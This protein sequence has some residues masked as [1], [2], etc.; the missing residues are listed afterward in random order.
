LIPSARF[1]LPVCNVTGSIPYWLHSCTSGI[2]R[3]KSL[4]VGH[5]LPISKKCSAHNK[6]MHMPRQS[7]GNS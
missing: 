2:Q 6:R 7:R 3:V 4:R 5:Y 1:T